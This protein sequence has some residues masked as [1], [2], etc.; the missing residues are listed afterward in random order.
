MAE[1]P[2]LRA[3]KPV[4]AFLCG[5]PHETPVVLYACHHGIVRKAVVICVVPEIVWPSIS[6]K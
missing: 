6:Q 2:E 1:N 5:K 3:V 4:K